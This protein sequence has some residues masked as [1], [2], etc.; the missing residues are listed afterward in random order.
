MSKKIESKLQFF[1]DC[2][3]AESNSQTIWNYPSSSSES[4][5][6]FE[7]LSS[8][9]SEPLTLTDAYH[10][11][12]VKKLAYYKR[13]KYL[14]LAAYFLK[15]RFAVPSFSGSKR[16]RSISCPI[17]IFPCELESNRKKVVSVDL[18]R[19]YVNPAAVQILAHFGI[20]STLSLDVLLKLIKKSESIEEQTRVIELLSHE[21][22]QASLQEMS[23]SGAFGMS[24]ESKKDSAKGA[25][26][27]LELML[28]GRFFSSPLQSLLKESASL[29]P[30]FWKWLTRGFFLRAHDIPLPEV[31]SEAQS[32]V[33]DTA[34]KYPL[35]VVSGPPGTGKSF[36][37]ACLAIREFSKG[38]SVLVVSQ[39]QHAADVV[40]RK[41][42]DQMGI[43]PGLTVLGS[44]QGVAPEVKQQIRRMLSSYGKDKTTEL[45]T[46]KRQLR[47]LTQERFDLE[48]GFEEKIN[49]LSEPF[50]DQKEDINT[51]FWT[52]GR[53]KQSTTKD[54]LYTDFSNLERLDEEIKSLI[55]QYM[56]AHYSET[57]QD[58]VAG[59]KSRES[60]EFFA[61]SLTARN[62]HYQ[63]KYYQEVNFDH[64]L[65]AIPFWFSSLGNLHRLLPLNEEMFDLVVID[66]A[67]QC[68]M[69]VCLPALQRA[70]RAVIL[71]DLK[72]LKHVSFVSYV[73]QQKLAELHALDTRH[74]SD[75]FRSNSVLDYAMSACELAEQSTL[76]DEHF[77]SHP[78]II[79]FSNSEF[80]QNKLKIMTER[81]NNRERSVEIVQVDG[82]RLNK[83]VNKKEAE[84]ILSKIKTIIS[85]QRSLPETEVHTLGV[86]AFFSSQA[87]HIEKM[88]FNEIGLNDMR[89]HNIR[90]GSPF[91]FQ[92]EERSHMLISCSV[93][94]KTSGNSYTYLNRDDVFNVAV[95]RARDYQTLFISCDSDELKPGSK[96][97][98]YLKFMSEYHYQ[99]ELA[100]SSAHD[101][102][103]DEIANWLSKR[104]VEVFKNYTVAGIKI[105]I[106][107]VFHGHAVAI[108][109]IGYQGDSREALHLTQFK[110]LQRAGLQSFLLPYQEWREQT[111]EVL[112]KLMLRLGVAHDLP[113]AVTPLDKFSDEDEA[114]FIAITRGL[115]INELNARF[116][117]NEEVLAVEQLSG[118]VSR[119]HRFVDLLNTYLFPQE[120]TY[121]RYLN[122]FKELLS[123]CLANL[124]EAS[125]VTELANSMFQ[126]QK[127]LYGDAQFDNE[128]DDVIAARLSM[129]DQ[130]RAKF[131]ALISENEKAILQMDTTMLKLSDFGKDEDIGD[132][133]DALKGLTE[134]L[135][136][137]KG[138][139]RINQK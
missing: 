108:D 135:E 106:M 38:N 74:V 40:R 59:S 52:F 41:L 21:L 17:L 136:L 49:L 123:Y 107:A 64:V 31:L 125:V 87:T 86:L 62:Q 109:L 132:P 18:A 116:L 4:V 122:T 119:Y 50:D 30:S 29:K 126:Q 139:T 12:V 101:S 8:Q 120:L 28:G 111:E 3:E 85:E 77:R 105:D 65:K 13:E 56:E 42:I 7:P 10:Q 19:G 20:D 124:K 58:L 34:A 53:A 32:K 118:L 133:T 55:I 112:H 103:Q 1:K 26:F 81:P 82:E 35:S 127:S 14:R 39:N 130:Q 45:K 24:V 93:D 2:L 23:F 99:H 90:V 137:Y 83:G 89:R 97:K 6:N 102:F 129:I 76:L 44:E 70:K 72:Q 11:K 121:R 104:G 33:L 128:F 37:I 95:T 88:V 57:S 91:S 79:Q 48:I 69:A 63:E 96:L 134:R 68:N 131:K 114:E 94:A 15:G 54:L 36:T 84:V 51:G 115:S 117:R 92:G 22:D 110:L 27:E 67:T 66:E 16:F 100:P 78:Q 80:Y 47:K 61:K 25:L 60:L 5:R 73:E 75:D 43:E 113:D 71:G 46:L 9:L 98:S 138:K